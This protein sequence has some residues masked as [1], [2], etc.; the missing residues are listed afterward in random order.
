MAACGMTLMAPLVRQPADHLRAQYHGTCSL[1]CKTE[2]CLAHQSRTPV[3]NVRGSTG[4]MGVAAGPIQLVC[5]PPC[6][7][8]AS[9]V[10]AAWVVPVAL[11]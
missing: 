6:L 4:C 7:A 3:E 1:G 11:H 9:Q 10:E 8:S 2:S 5:T